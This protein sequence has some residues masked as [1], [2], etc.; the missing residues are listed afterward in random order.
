VS[1][2]LS[3]VAAATVGGTIA[4]SIGLSGLYLLAAVFG[5]VAV[6]LIALAVR[7]ATTRP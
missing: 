2:S 1:F 5:T 6:G 7:R 3:G 4:T